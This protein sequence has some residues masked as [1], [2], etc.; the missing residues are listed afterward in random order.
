MR[1]RNIQYD[2]NIFYKF[3]KIG[4]RELWVEINRLNNSA[5][6]TKAIRLVLLTRV[7]TIFYLYCRKKSIFGISL[8]FCVKIFSYYLLFLLF[9]LELKFGFLGEPLFLLLK[10]T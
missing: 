3:S 9:V 4:T 6:P 5:T 10:G 7:P 2:L 8:K 1:P